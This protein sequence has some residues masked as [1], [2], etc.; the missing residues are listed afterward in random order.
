M[1]LEHVTDIAGRLCADRGWGSP[2]YIDNGASA[3][4][5]K[6]QTDSG[7]AALKIYDPSFFDGEN[8]LIE[9]K[10]I[11]LQCD[12]KAHGCPYLV[13]IYE[14]GEALGEGTWYLLMEF[15]PWKSLEKR[16]AEVPDDKVHHLI[17]QLV[18]A[19][20][21]LDSRNLVHRDIKPANIVVSDDFSH[22][23]LLDFGVVRRIA[24][25]EGNGTDGHKFIATAQYSPPEFL[26]RDETPDEAG[27][28]AINLYQIGAV[29]HDLITKTPIFAEEKTTK[30]RFK[31]FKA[32]TEKRPRVISASVPPRLVALCMAALDKDPRTRLNSIKLDDFLADVDTLDSVRRRISKSGPSD[33]APL[34]PTL[35]VWSRHVRAWAKEA[36][37]LEAEALGAVTISSETTSERHRWKLS[38]AATGVPIYVEL[39]RIGEALVAVHVLSWPDAE[40]GAPAFVID[41]EGPSLPETGIPHALAAQYLYALELAVVTQ[42]SSRPAMEDLE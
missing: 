9:A 1:K 34:K 15:C 36:A 31:L 39:S 11:E 42:P 23:K 21:F 25:D 40:H 10:R 13:E 24:Y 3:A 14:A 35:A 18:K 26:A 29:L 12:L 33:I 32:V 20:Q 4:V 27:F 7:N 30:N 17:K 22:L 5:Y 19:V 41:S 16:L 28:R 6:V 37:E 8:A 2:D 38:F